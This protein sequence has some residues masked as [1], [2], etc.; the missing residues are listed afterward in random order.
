[1]ALGL[2]IFPLLIKYGLFKYSFDILLIIIWGITT[3]VSFYLIDKLYGKEGPRRHIV[4]EFDKKY[5]F[6]NENRYL[7]VLLLTIITCTYCYII[8]MAST[9]LKELIGVP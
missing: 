7:Q 9:K 2:I 8:M 5:N 1:M 3:I 6:K 4:K